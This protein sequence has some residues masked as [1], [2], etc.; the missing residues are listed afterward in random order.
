MRSTSV[1]PCWPTDLTS[2]A[3]GDLAYVNVLAAVEGAVTWPEGVLQFDDK[4][5]RRL[6]VPVDKVLEVAQLAGVKRLSVLY[7]PRATC[8]LVR[9][10]VHF[11][12]LL[13]RL[14]DAAKNGKGVLVGVIDSGI[15]GSHPDFTG[16]LIAFWDQGTPPL[17]AGPTPAAA[18]PA[19]TPLAA[20]YAGFNY[21]V[22]LQSAPLAPASAN[23]PSTAQDNN[24]VGHGTHVSGIAAGGG[25][26]DPANPGGFLVPPGFA[27]QASIAVVRAI[28]VG[29]QANFLDGITWIFQKATELNVPCVINM[30]FGE[31]FHPHD[32]TDDTSVATFFTVAD[33]TRQL[34]S[35][36][37]TRR[38]RRKRA[39]RP[40]SHAA[41]RSSSRQ[42]RFHG[43]D[44]GAFNLTAGSPVGQEPEPGRQPERSVPPRRRRPRQQ[45]APQHGCVG[46]A[47]DPHWHGRCC[48]KPRRNLSRAPYDHR[49]RDAPRRRSQEH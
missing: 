12:E 19:G 31:H 48:S 10:A 35:R 42:H 36:A 46:D 23:P 13:T 20:A 4:P 33:A 26:P 34:H 16:R 18:H 2:P 38:G 24:R 9:T 21:G 40:H 17:V 6:A 32:G 41:Q 1:T 29:P 43:A 49:D 45:P 47:I 5:V 15:D 8:D 11:D 27:S 14:P 3:V 30:S 7:Q 44:S 39:H 37:H 25:V 22:E 28:E